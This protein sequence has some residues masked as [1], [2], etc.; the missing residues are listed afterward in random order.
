MYPRILVDLEK[1]SHNA[2]TV[3]SMMKNTGID[4]PFVVT[5]M[6]A[7]NKAIAKIFEKTGFSYLA[8]SRIDNL[9]AFESIAMKKVLLRIPMGFEAKKVIRFSDISLNSELETIRILNHEA[10]KQGKNHKIILMF[11]LG[12]LREGIWFDDDYIVLVEEILKLTHIDLFG[13]GTNLTCYGGVIPTTSMMERL[14]EMKRTIESTFNI[15]IPIVS[16]GNSSS[17]H[18]VM[19]GLM[20]DGINNL[21]LGEIIVLGRETSFGQKIEGLYDDVFTVEAKVI[22]LKTKPSYPIGET[23]LD[24]FGVVPVIEDKG[25]M[26]RAI[27]AIGKQDVHPHNLTPKDPSLHVIG[28]SSDHL[29]MEDTFSKLHLQDTVS[30]HLNYPGLLQCMT[31]KYVYKSLIKNAI[32]T[33]GKGK[34]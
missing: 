28:G 30:F 34:S 2:M 17:I 11:D 3:F 10:Q 4:H 9:K 29:I 21:R 26:R 16:G 31:S 24:S 22:E 13:I 32:T 33:N 20:P 23:G 6:L 1:L 18:L 15:F 27:L 25:M 19:Q 7:G 12:D 14:I 8:D 5:K